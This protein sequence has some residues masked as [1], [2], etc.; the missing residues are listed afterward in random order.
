M[1]AARK[2]APLALIGLGLLAALLLAVPQALA[3]RPFELRILV[4]I[5]LFATLGHGWNI[6][7]GYAGQSSIGHGMFFGLGAYATT[8][9]SLKWGVNPWIGAVAGAAV[10]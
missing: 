8:V 1:P 5:F 9:V 3:D 10:A 2:A 7:G 6:L 4:L